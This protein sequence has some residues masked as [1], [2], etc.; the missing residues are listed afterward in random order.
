MVPSMADGSTLVERPSDPWLGGYRELLVPGACVLD[1]GCGHGHDSRE[2]LD[3]GMDVVAIDRDRERIA[4]A[5]SIAPG[6]HFVHGD[7]TGPLPFEDEVFDLVV[8]SLSIH[9]FSLETTLH[10]IREVARVLRPGSR[11]LCRVNRVGDINFEYGKGIELEP[12]FFEVE[13][14]R[15]KRFF[16]PE[17]LRLALET[18]LIVEEI[19]SGETT[20]WGLV[21]RTLHAR[22]RRPT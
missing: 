5:R 11:L 16:S 8:A 15:C 3:A 1:L 7:I 13:P 2:L 22:A 10:I 12:D 6:A 4:A 17:S 20:R 19:A 21:K 18:S 14:G 9:Y